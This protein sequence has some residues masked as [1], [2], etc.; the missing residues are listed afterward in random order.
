[1]IVN[2]TEIPGCYEIRPVIF[3]DERGIFVKTFHQEVFAKNQL[4]TYFAEEYYS[5][6]HH[7]VLRGLH[8]QM[9]PKDHIKLVYCVSGE[10]IDTVVD[11]RRGS[12]TYGKFQIFTLNAEKSNILYIPSGLAHGFY[13]ISENAILVYKTTTV[14]SPE[15]DAGILWNSVGIPWPNEKPIISKR[16][17]EFVAFEDFVTPFIYQEG[18]VDEKQ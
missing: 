10:V 17:S 15:H 7:G 8:F 11:L 12:P 14:Y 1:M 3:K 2:K 18:C 4:A 9:P 6:S 5:F 16:D 13:V